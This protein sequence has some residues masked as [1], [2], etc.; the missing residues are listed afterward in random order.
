MMLGALL[1]CG[2]LLVVGGL[3]GYGAACVRAS[4]EF[5]AMRCGQCGARLC[6][7]VER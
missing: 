5:E 7:E 6:K 3:L 4:V 1:W 2:L